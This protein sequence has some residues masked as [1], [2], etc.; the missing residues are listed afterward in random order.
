MSNFENQFTFEEVEKFRSRYQEGEEPVLFHLTRAVGDKETAQSI[1]DGP[2]EGMIKHL[3]KNPE[4]VEYD[5][6]F[7]NLY[8]LGAAK[9][10]RERKT[11]AAKALDNV[12]DVFG[13]ASAHG[14]T[15]ALAEQGEFIANAA[16]TL[17]EATFGNPMEVLEAEIGRTRE[18]LERQLRFQN[19]G[20]EQIPGLRA[21]RI[22]R[23]QDELSQL[24]A[25]LEK[26]RGSPEEAEVFNNQNY[27]DFDG[28]DW[29]DEFV[30]E[31]KTATGQVVE[32]ITQFGTGFVLPAGALN[33]LRLIGQA[34][35]K[36]RA[37]AGLIA[38]MYSDFAAFDPDDPTLAQMLNEEFDIDLGV[39]T[40]YLTKTDADGE[41]EKR[42]KS[43]LEGAGL[44]VAAE[45]LF[46]SVRAGVR[47]Y[48]S[49]STSKDAQRAIAE[50]LGGLEVPQ[51]PHKL[52]TPQE[53]SQKVSEQVKVGDE[54]LKID[55]QVA[56]VTEGL[57][58]PKGSTPSNIPA[59]Q[60]AVRDA[61]EF[62][63]EADV[64]FDSEI[65]DFTDGILKEDPNVTTPDAKRTNQSRADFAKRTASN[66]LRHSK[67]GTEENWAEVVEWVKSTPS[68]HVP[69]VNEAIRI[70]TDAAKR[71]M[72]K[73]FD[74][75]EVA[76]VSEKMDPDK[77]A[78]IELQLDDA[79]MRYLNFRA[80]DQD[81]A[82]QVGRELQA[83][84][85][86]VNL[87]DARVSQDAPKANLSDAKTKREISSRP[88]RGDLVNDLAEYKRLRA[89]GATPSVA[90]SLMD[91]KAIEGRG[92]NLRPIKGHEPP[93]TLWQKLEQYLM[94]FRY[95]AMLSGTA[96]HIANFASGSANI[97]R[98]TTSELAYRDTRQFGLDR[99]AGML[100]G[101]REASHYALRAGVEF[102][103]FLAETDK[104]DYR[105][106]IPIVDI[107]LR[108]MMSADELMRQ[109]QYRGEVTAKAAREGRA[110]GKTGETLKTYVDDQLAK[111]LDDGKALDRIAER[112]AANVVAQNR[113]SAQSRYRGERVMASIQH[114]AE[115][116]FAT[117]LLF[118]FSRVS[119]DLLDMG[120]RM[121][122]GVR[123]VVGHV[124]RITGGNS[125]FLDDLQGLNGQIAQSRARSDVYSGY[126]LATG[127]ILMGLEGNITGGHSYD[128]KQ[129]NIQREVAPEYSIRFGDQ[130]FR[131]DKFEPFATPLKYI[132][133]IS[134][135][136]HNYDELVASGVDPDE[137][138]EATALTTFMM[139]E[140]VASQP[141]AETIEQLGSLLVDGAQGDSKAVERFTVSLV[142][143]FVPN[144]LKKTNEALE[145]D[146]GVTLYRQPFDAITRHFTSVFPQFE[147]DKRRS[148]LTGDLK[149]KAED[150]ITQEF[151]PMMPAEFNTS[152][153]MQMLAKANE[154]YGSDYHLTSS[155]QLTNGK[156]TDL[157]QVQSST[158]SRSVYDH[159]LEI[160]STY[161]AESGSINGLDVS[162]LTYKEA[163]DALAGDPNFKRLPWIRQGAN[164][165]HVAGQTAKNDWIKEIKREYESLA[166]AELEKRDTA[167]RELKFSIDFEQKRATPKAEIEAL[168]IN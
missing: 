74:D 119:L 72:D 84:K 106:R 136:L 24:E 26:L 12:I 8:G 111:S 163:L 28:S 147:G 102:K 46:L 34:G 110:L 130:W 48:R 45:A 123:A 17:D 82:S 30:A 16:T 21:S 52:V 144:I 65:R 5:S 162:G 157:K 75:F 151:I 9:Y 68:E 142:E 88:A 63:K 11:G 49:R 15:N 14:V 100:R 124:H 104:F 83:R 43:S 114:F 19:T 31:P 129:A 148:P 164:Q 61:F 33:R 79:I 90:K 153:G 85:S 58:F 127:A 133:A 1:L 154:I 128:Y 54:T 93:E 81:I 146:N 25:R 7:D 57:E 42:F 4:D 143:S 159:Y 44:G 87:E 70:A 118:A 113:F 60:K 135:S 134:D 98:Y 55:Q 112:N 20:K 125:Q 35:V 167:Y 150:K 56:D 38:G 78:A 13:R 2:D 27:V 40:D 96:T 94:T 97:L 71:R 51:P 80:I 22:A 161:R 69:V 121:T 91:A 10:H 67:E 137:F 115:S 168:E 152:P 29:I 101:L 37:A 18:S 107:P 155:T 66:L 158:G 6:H 122:P 117:R 141:Y 89:E 99:T 156:N 139:A 132:A 92:L 140:T 166:K 53:A 64:A 41:Y 47:A 39:T 126:A 145:G 120:Q 149:V 103:P 62:V 3:K 105:T 116:N 23:T 138:A 73:I 109:I 36:G 86:A 77:A 131:Y 165:D 59:K 76:R 160:V 95:S 50:S 32:G 108:A